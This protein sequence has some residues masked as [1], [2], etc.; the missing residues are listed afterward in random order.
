ARHSTQPVPDGGTVG[1]IAAVV[2]LIGSHRLPLR[3]T[4]TGLVQHFEG[5]DVLVPDTQNRIVA[6][7]QRGPAVFALQLDVLV[8]LTNNLVVVPVDHPVTRHRLP[9]RR[10]GLSLHLAAQTHAAAVVA[11]AA[12]SSAS[13]T[14]S[15]TSDTSR[16]SSWS[17]TDSGTSSRSGSLRCGRKT[18]V[19]P[20][21]CAASSF[22]LTPPIGSTRPFN[23]TSPVMPT[24]DRTA[25]PLAS[26]ARAVTIV[27][28]ADGPSF[29]TAPAGTCRCSVRLNSVGSMPRSR[30]CARR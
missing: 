26:D 25:R 1:S 24:S 3:L 10:Q 21:R 14:R 28:P 4:G 27:T 5:L 13:R 16:I 17:R 22:C 19:R 23:V 29:G 6:V 12:D 18:V 15:A 8:G 7:E 30:P 2:S 20:A 11:G 9:F